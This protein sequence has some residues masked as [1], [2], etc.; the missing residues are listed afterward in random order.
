MTS[1]DTPPPAFPY[2]PEF[3]IEQIERVKAVL[4]QA[5][6]LILLPGP[7]GA[8]NRTHALLPDASNGTQS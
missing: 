3:T 1:I 5:G 4:E 8:G 6:H 2:R 7:H